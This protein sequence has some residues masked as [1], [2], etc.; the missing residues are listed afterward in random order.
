MLTYMHVC[1]MRW[2]MSARMYIYEYVSSI[3]LLVY[4]FLSSHLIVSYISFDITPVTFALPDI[5]D[6]LFHG[7]GNSISITKY[8]PKLSFILHYCLLCFIMLYILY[9]VRDSG[10]YN[11]DVFSNKSRCFI[12]L[13]YR[14]EITFFSNSFFLLFRK[15]TWLN[16]T[17]RFLPLERLFIFS[18]WPIKN[19]IGYWRRRFVSDS[20]STVSGLAPRWIEGWLLQGLMLFK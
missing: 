19:S 9:T 15:V 5:C 7:N 18:M 6:D 1:T 2:C 8:L 4:V 20:W 3:C 10:R 13:L 16:N 17:C 12:C 11:E 14:L